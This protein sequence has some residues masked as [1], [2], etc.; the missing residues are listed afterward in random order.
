[1]LCVTAAV[2]DLGAQEFTGESSN[3]SVRHRTF[4]ESWRTDRLWLEFDPSVN[5]MF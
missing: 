2:T 5:A 4:Q 3:K 1:M